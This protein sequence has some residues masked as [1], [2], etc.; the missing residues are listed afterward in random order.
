MNKRERVGR[1]NR[2]WSMVRDN[3]IMNGLTAF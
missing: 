2:E 1:N 3:A